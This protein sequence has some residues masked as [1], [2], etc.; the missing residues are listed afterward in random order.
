MLR[1]ILDPY[2]SKMKGEYWAPTKIVELGFCASE[3]GIIFRET[4]RYKFFR[5]H[6]VEK[7]KRI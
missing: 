6:E 7:N 4:Y 2:K 5:K 3:T 1:K